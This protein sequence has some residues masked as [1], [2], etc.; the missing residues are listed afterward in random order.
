MNKRYDSPGSESMR[1]LLRRYLE[2]ET[3]QQETED[4][5]ALLQ[6]SNVWRR[7][8]QRMKNFLAA[9]QEMPLCDPPENVWR[10]ISSS[11]KTM[12]PKSV[13]FPWY[14]AHPNWAFAGRAMSLLL[15]VSAG[16]ILVLNTQ[17]LSPGYLVVTADDIKGFGREAETY[18]ALHDLNGNTPQTTETLVAFYTS[19][20][21]E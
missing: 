4:V 16:L 13:W 15:A 20:W 21:T 9:L 19:G 8:L 18:A 11:I 12:K 1:L 6:R 7:E 2:N 17:F 14:Y 10:S 3:S 5:A